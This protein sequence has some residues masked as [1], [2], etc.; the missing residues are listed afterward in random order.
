MYRSFLD[1]RNY[2]LGV[3]IF[4]MP[5]IFLLT[6]IF[7]LEVYLPYVCMGGGGTGGI[8]GTGCIGG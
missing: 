5:N 6:G 7:W 2:F 1:V 4:L 8:R 3:R